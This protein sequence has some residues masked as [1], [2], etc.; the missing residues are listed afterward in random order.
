ML[1][2]KVD[3]L[4]TTYLGL[5]VGSSP[6]NYSFWQPIISRVEKKLSVWKSRLLSAGARV[7]LVNSVLTSLPLYFCSLFKMPMVVVNKLNSLIRS[8][9]W[10]DGENNR[11]TRWFA[12]GKI[13]LNKSYGGLGIPDIRK[14][15]IALLAKWWNRFCLEKDALWKCVIIEK[16]YCHSSQLSPI[17]EDSN[18]LSKC[19]K[20]ILDVGESQIFSAFSNNFLGCF[21]WKLGFGDKIK[22]WHDNW[23]SNLPLKTL[24]PRL[25]A[26]A[27]NQDC[28]VASMGAFVNSNQASWSWNIATISTPRGRTSTELQDLLRLLENLSPSQ[29]EDAFMWSASPC[30]SSAVLYDLMSPQSAIL[31]PEVIDIIWLKWSPPRVRI[32]SWKLAHDI[33]P[34]KWNLLCRGII[35]CDFDPLCPL[36]NQELEHQ[37]HLFLQCPC[38]IPLW[39]K[40]SNW[41]GLYFIIPNSLIQFLQQCQAVS[42]HTGI[43]Q[44]F[45]T[46][47]ICT[48]W[49]IWFGRNNL[50]FNGSGWDSENLFHFIQ[51][52]TFA[53]FR[54]LAPEKFFTPS[55]WFL[56][57][58]EAAKLFR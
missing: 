30:F 1:N 55:D 37:D 38:V 17:L 39:A 20:D 31:P 45:Q 23:A 18:H 4:P 12:W 58:I 53:W 47:C 44:L 5:P 41:W 52:R 36:C 13:C 16:Y 22:F 24:F 27:L 15:N 33:L 6:R 8:F 25:F 14:R 56:Y 46:V 50:V 10:G 19:W 35:A 11:K 54:S 21:K 49:S 51:S 29:H 32:F 2:C 42:N 9:F 26:F 43:N 3:K 57:P 7:T 40:I 48:L 28:S 34:I